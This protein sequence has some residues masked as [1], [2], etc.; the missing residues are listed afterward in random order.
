MLHLWLFR[1]V[2]VEHAGRRCRTGV[3][4]V[5]HIHSAVYRV[6]AFSFFDRSSSFNILLIEFHYI[7]LIFYKILTY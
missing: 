5:H 2:V 7:F 4:L 1:T 6:D 3:G